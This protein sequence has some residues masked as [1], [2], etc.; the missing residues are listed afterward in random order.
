VARPGAAHVPFTV[1]GLALFN[2]MLAEQARLDG[3]SV[4]ACHESVNDGEGLVR[5]WRVTRLTRL[6]I[7]GPSAQAEA[8]GVGWHQITR[9]AGAA[10]PRHLPCA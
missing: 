6:G 10:V 3:G 7:P 2:V 1:A 5:Q 4:Q 9:L 8:D